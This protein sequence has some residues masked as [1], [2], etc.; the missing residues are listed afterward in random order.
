MPVP[1]ELPTS[2]LPPRVVVEAPA[3]LHLGFFDLNGGLGRCFGSLGVAL[4]GLATRV[5]ASA[6]DVFGASGAQAARAEGFARRMAAHLRSDSGLRVVVEQALPEHVGLGSGTQLALAV[7]RAAA[8]LQ[9]RALPAREVASVL[10]RGARSGIGVAAFEQ[11]GFVVDGGRSPQR[12]AVPPL[13]ARLAVPASWRWI[14]V[15]DDAGRGLSGAA[16]V[17]AFRRLPPFPEDAAARLCRVVLMQILPALAEADI[18]RFGA[19]LTRLQ[20]CV[21]DHFAPAQG[22]RYASARVAVALRVL[23]Q[24]GAAAIGQTSWGPTGFALAPGPEQAL[25]LVDGVRRELGEVPLRFQIHATR[26]R[27]ADVI[28]QPEQRRPPALARP[29]AYAGARA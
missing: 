13:L 7:G 10:D 9:G 12:D 16:E 21:G 5:S 6:A 24:A 8:Q 1:I 18:A 22:G 3:R 15:F 19:G 17:Q 29:L 27:G 4:D 25:A 14:L 20:D 23:Q 26:N 2:G 11:G 28:V